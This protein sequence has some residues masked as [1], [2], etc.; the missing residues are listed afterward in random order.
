MGHPTDIVG[1]QF[2]AEILC[3]K[4]TVQQLFNDIDKAVTFGGAVHLDHEDYEDVLDRVARDWYG[5]D[6]TDES[7]FDTDVFPKVVFSDTET[8]GVCGTCGEELE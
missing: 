3:P 7:T 5:I 2:H 1:Y 4:C 6:R 8:D